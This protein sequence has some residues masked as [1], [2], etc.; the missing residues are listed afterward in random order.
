MWQCIL[1]ESTFEIT[2]IDP[3]WW[4]A[5]SLLHVLQG[6]L[7]KAEFEK[8]KS[9]E[10]WVDPYRREVISLFQMWQVIHTTGQLEEAWDITHRWEAICLCWV[11]QVIV[12]FKL[13]AVVFYD[14]PPN[15][16]SEWDVC[17]MNITANLITINETKCLK[18]V[19]TVY[20]WMSRS[21]SLC[22]MNALSH[23]EQAF[24]S[25]DK[26]IFF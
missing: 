6:I 21:K 1:T 17:T 2:L 12:N 23:F 26:F 8:A 15:Y 11:W 4:I 5:I 10:S 3:H 9:K 25:E 24:S 22:C 14:C 19:L 20:W 7:T 16:R 18:C 13:W